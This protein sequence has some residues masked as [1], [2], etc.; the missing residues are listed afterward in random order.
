MRGRIEEIKRL[1]ETYKNKTRV[2]ERIEMLE[3]ENKDLHKLIDS[4]S[5]L[6]KGDAE[7]MGSRR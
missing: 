7:R 5:E 6:I 2:Q 3:M 1:V 4:L